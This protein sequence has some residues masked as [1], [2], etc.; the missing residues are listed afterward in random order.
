MIRLTLGELMISESLEIDG[1]LATDVVITADADGDDVTLAGT[2]I[3]DVLASFGGTDGAADDFLDD[4][5]RVLNFF[6]STGNLTIAGLTI[7]G[8]QAS[9]GS[10]Y[11]GGV[12]FDSIGTLLVDQ[13]A[14]SGNGTSGYVGN[15]GG[16]FTNS[17]AVVLSYSTVS[18]NNTR[19]D[20]GR[21]GGIYNQFGIV[22]LDNS[23]VSGNST[24]GSF[25]GGGAGG[26]QRC[27]AR[28]ACR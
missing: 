19:G 14:V 27:G 4:N 3:T 9:G 6:N 2:T 24:T 15:G 16:I 17:G 21:G 23:V 5:S 12:L 18:E 8:G 20:R 10:V 7:T 26:F 25:G 1:T 13:S 11:G 22:S 28:F